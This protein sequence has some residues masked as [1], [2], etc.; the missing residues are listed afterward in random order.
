MCNV[1]PSRRAFV[2]NRPVDK[3]E[4]LEGTIVEMT[5][6]EEESTFSQLTEVPVT[7]V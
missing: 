3:C 2:P 5:D 7:G 1:S 4:D 6:V